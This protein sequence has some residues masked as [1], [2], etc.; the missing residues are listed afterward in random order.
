MWKA[1]TDKS[2]LRHVRRLSTWRCM[3]CSRPF[4]VQSKGNIVVSVGES[5]FC[6]TAY[7]ISL[8]FQNIP[9]DSDESEGDQPRRKRVTHSKDP[10]SVVPPTLVDVIDL[11]EEVPDSQTGKPSTP[12]NSAPIRQSEWVGSQAYSASSYFTHNVVSQEPRRVTVVDDDSDNSTPREITPPLAQI[13]QAHSLPPTPPQWSVET[14][15]LPQILKEETGELVISTPVATKKRPL[16]SKPQANRF[17]PNS[18]KG[19]KRVANFVNLHLPFGYE[20]LPVVDLGTL[21]DA[22]RKLGVNV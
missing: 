2:A 17:K 14:R 8:T 16:H 20:P 18:R 10:A 5:R 1:E 19:K 3:R 22:L 12:D 7:R 9:S 15:L 13:P 6:C 11:T 21:D 4:S